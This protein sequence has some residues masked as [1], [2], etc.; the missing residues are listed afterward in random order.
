MTDS[1]A[2]S[3]DTVAIIG[4]GAIGCGWAV[5]FASAGY[6]VRVFDASA[7][8]RSS[9]LRRA[10]AALEQLSAIR[11]A[12]SAF[13]AIEQIT[14]VNDLAEAVANARLVQE[15]ILEDRSAKTA[16]FS[17]IEAF[18]PDQ[19]ILAS[20]TSEI[21]GSE[22]FS[23]LKRPERA[24]VGHPLNPPHLIPIVEIAP[25]PSTAAETVDAYAAIMRDIGQEVLIL[26]KEVGGFVVNRLQY[27]LAAEALRLVREGY[28]DPEAIDQAM[29]HGLGLRWATHGPLET[30]YLNAGGDFAKF[31]GQYGPTMRNIVNSLHPTWDLPDDLIERLNAYGKRRFPKGTVI[32]NEERFEILIRLRDHL[33]GA[34]AGPTVAETRAA[35][36]GTEHAR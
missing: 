33:E 18:A 2:G 35:S 3:A 12:E 21:P 10:A 14:V 16:V 9:G 26:K 29:K 34:L 36:R 17:E 27:A 15:N 1:R 11:P 20:S 30:M 5:K 13:S 32:A 31:I 22:I 6:K 25:S 4:F 28:C 19:A 24:L 7:D 23:V 8:A